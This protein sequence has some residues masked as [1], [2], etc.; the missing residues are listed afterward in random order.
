MNVQVAIVVVGVLT[1]AAIAMTF[2]LFH[3]R[4]RR[5]ADDRE[6]G[7]DIYG[8][9]AGA[10]ALLI[11]F[12]FSI[13][14]EDYHDADVAAAAEA[15][16]VLAMARA[17]EF[18]EQPLQQHLQDDLLC[19]ARLVSTVEWDTMRRGVYTVS[20]PVQDTLMDMDRAIS[21]PEGQQ[22]AGAAVEFWVEANNLRASARGGRLLAGE[23]FIPAIVWVMLIL[24]VILMIGSLLLFVGHS[25]R[26]W[27]HSLVVIGPI[28]I[29]VSGMVVI[30]FFENPYADLPGGI[31]PAA[32]EITIEAMLD[33]R[34]S[35]GQ[36]MAPRC[37]TDIAGSAVFAA[38]DS[39]T[40]G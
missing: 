36:S 17:S 13:A 32:M 4:R 19:Y 34:A 37:P 35:L 30:F 1:L 16:Q 14:F 5:D 26:T 7:A 38:T 12:T 9:T 29:A 10:L 22:Q 23:W 40:V 18:M 28:F 2:A 25:R 3:T 15:S 11:A 20:G 8:V 24:G 31:R 6:V 27:L 33:Q 39:G 21:S